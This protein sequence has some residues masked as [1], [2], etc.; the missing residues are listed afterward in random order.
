M[1]TL[2]ITSL[3]AGG[4]GLA[5]V[6]CNR[7]G[8]AGALKG[9]PAVMHA[10]RK[11]D[12]QPDQRDQIHEIMDSRHDGIHEAVQPLVVSHVRIIKQILDDEYDEAAV[13]AA[14]EDIAR[15]IQAAALTL[16]A[17]VSEVREVLT[18]EQRAELE[19]MKKKA[20]A[21]HERRLGTMAEVIDTL[22]D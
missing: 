17:T 18:E 10:L 8:H 5:T 1:K 13:R 6:G 9:R 15:Q 7:S 20:I 22:K 14:S 11:L 2:I 16:S 4:L 12:I 3:I 19:K 21:R